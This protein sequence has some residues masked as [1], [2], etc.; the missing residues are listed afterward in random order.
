MKKL[1][2][3]LFLC[4]SSSFG[5][6]KFRTSIET[7]SRAIRTDVPMTNS[8]KKAFEAG[9]RDFTGK[10]G[11]NYWQLETDF[12][13]DAKLDPSTQTI[14]G[15]ETITIHNNSKVDLPN[16]VLRLDHNI[17][18]ADVPRG[19]STPAEQTE[20]MVVTS[21]KVNGTSIDLDLPPARRNDP[22]ALRASN[23]TKTV[24]YITLEK[25][26]PAG[27]TGELEISWHTKLPGGTAGRGHRMTQRFDS[28]LF[29]PTQWFPR[30]AKYD[31]LRGWETSEYLG[32]AEF[33]NNFGKFDVSLTVPAG[34]IVSGTG[35][36]QNPEEVLTPT[37]IQ[38][39]ST[40]LGT[41]EEVTIVS[42]EE[43]G[44]GKSTK[45]GETLTW[46]FLAD[47]VN[48]F[49]WATSDRFIW[50]ATRA[51]IPEKGAI[52]IHMV[53]IPERAQYFEHAGERARHAL[54]F[55]SSLWVPYP[56]PQLTMQDGPSAGMEYPMV[57][58]S[59]QGAADHEVAH[60]WW[61][62]MVGTNETRYGWMDEGFNQFMNIL[63]GADSKGVPFDLDR[64]GQ[65]YGRMSGNEDEAPLMWSAN[66]A[67]SGYGY[68]TYLKTPLMLSMLGG[69]VGDD[70]VIAAMK[71]YAATW[72][73]KHPSPWDYMFFMDH[74]LGENLGWFWYY[75]LF[76]TES[77][78]GSIKSVEVNSDKTIVTVRQDGEM[79]S[80]IILQVEYE[81]E[82][83][84][85]SELENAVM[86]SPNTLEFSYPVDVWL[87][88]KREYKVE[89]PNLK[90]I[91][92]ITLDPHNRFPDKDVTDN[93]W[94]K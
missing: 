36:L 59:N 22:P 55:Y 27:S 50:K 12:V 75:W 45:N 71:K 33:F 3:L 4:S 48:D 65:S 94:S 1:L 15:T 26:I 77:V 9:T 66:N 56:F 38:R 92:K 73:F 2:L 80:P 51:M 91:K 78:D 70:A 58:N 29:Q 60:Q 84:G 39:L 40:V 93:T 11:P 86:I 47:K 67:G 79:P 13:I 25:P 23:L 69:I 63:S 88:G 49:A 81:G 72:A 57:I 32:P 82:I 21:I 35:V 6:E 52:P 24:A 41:D 37:A 61:P 16:L 28:T 31:D 20:G 76:T 53:F 87:D 5:Q 17:F 89:I 62:M 85:V 30:L 34:W 10:P 19:S 18:R 14:T 54:E 90:S 8:I 7:D 42:Q 68:Q 43:N 83:G 64:W 74:A 46:R 44:P